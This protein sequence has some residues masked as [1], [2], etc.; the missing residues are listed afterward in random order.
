MLLLLM[1]MQFETP[2]AVVILQFST[3]FGTTWLLLSY[4]TATIHHTQHYGVDVVRVRIAQS[5]SNAMSSVQHTVAML[6]TQ[7]CACNMYVTDG[8]KRCVN[9]T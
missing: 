9:C 6:N 4:A 3:S 2:A 1:S 8:K 7:C 5:V